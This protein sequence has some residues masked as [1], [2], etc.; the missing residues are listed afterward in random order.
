[1]GDLV[2]I[3]REGAVLEI[4][5][6]RPEKKNALTNAM[7]QDIVAA[8]TAGEADPGVRVLLIGAEGSVFTAGNDIGD[9]ARV[10]MGAAPAS[11]LQALRFIAALAGAHKPVVAA[12]PGLA[13]GVGATMLL[14]CD[15]V[16]VAEDAVLSTPFVNLAL[17]PE[18]ASS[19]LL[20]QRVGH[21]RAFAM[22]ALGETLS[23]RA[24][25]DLGIANAALPRDQVLA[26]ARAAAA[27]LA[28]RPTGAVKATKALMRDGARIEAAMAQEN[29]LFAER[30]QSAEARE[31][32]AAFAER[33]PPDFTALD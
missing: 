33:R 20:P 16:F 19:V 8:I 13:V 29:A 26:A 5:L 11:E 21:V 9:F 30:L 3:E 31:A 7:Y 32:F 22:F 4:L 23:G 1:M 10:A 14:H 24:A 2:Q 28:L 18:A 27:A 6:A 17:T 12:V 15:L 25:A